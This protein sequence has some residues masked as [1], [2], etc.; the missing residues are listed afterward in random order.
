VLAVLAGTLVAAQ[1][2]FTAGTAQTAP[3]SPVT[4]E[5][6]GTASGGWQP[7]IDDF[8]AKYPTITVK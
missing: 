4:I 7:V 1:G 8:Q 6:Y 3:S 5:L 2:A